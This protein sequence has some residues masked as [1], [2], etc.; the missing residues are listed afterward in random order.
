M[1][2]DVDQKIVGEMPTQLIDN[3]LNAI[4]E[5]DWYAG[6][7]RQKVGNMDDCNSIPIHHTPLCAVADCD[8]KAIRS[9]RK[10][11]M[12]NKFYPFLEPILNELSRH[13]QFNQYAA[14]MARLAPG[15][16]IGEHIDRGSFLE[17]CHRVHVPLKSNPKVRYVIDGQS[18]YWEP[19]KIYE[20]NNTKQHGVYNESDEYRI[21]LVVNLYNLTDEE[22]NKE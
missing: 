11:K 16:V 9:I 14:F 20:F 10:E 3:L 13:Y 22:L 19:G 5:E 21:H 8:G 7:Y 4:V 15:G 17:L 12:Y 18:Y 2:L 1:K 6:D